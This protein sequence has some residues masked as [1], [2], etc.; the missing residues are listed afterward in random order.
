MSNQIE[1][2]P[3]DQIR[4]DPDQPRKVFVN[5]D[6][7]AASIQ[8]KGL[9]EPIIVRPGPDGYIIVAG[10][11]RYRAARLVGMTEIDAIVRDITETESF[12][13]SLVENIQRESLTPIEE[14]EAFARLQETG[15]SQKE[16][17]DVTGKS[18]SYISQK[19]RLLKLP[20]FIQIFMDEGDLTENHCRQLLRLRKAYPPDLK[21]RGCNLEVLQSMLAG[22]VFNDLEKTSI[23][24]YM[25]RPME[26]APF[27]KVGE[28][29][30]KALRMHG[31]YVLQ[32]K[33][34]VPQWLQSALYFAVFVTEFDLTVG[35]LT[36]FVDTYIDSY[37]GC[38]IL[39]HLFT[40]TEKQEPALFW[41]AWGDLKHAN[42][43]SLSLEIDDS[44]V[45]SWWGR[46]LEKAFAEGSHGL[47]FDFEDMK[48]VRR[49]AVRE[50][51]KQYQ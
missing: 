41:A 27:C 4:P 45:G 9:M 42:S 30:Q 17:M 6:E 21:I 47:P 46:L 48:T 35:V 49:A 34:D 50:T 43:L 16:I 11:R 18:Q 29:S 32:H 44:P 25:Q 10:E 26:K 31:N 22:E 36:R 38:L 28:L 24:F 15:L 39:K 7:L 2:L 40:E 13:L 3:L 8:T 1:R 14:A 37:H 19:L 23:Y 12:Q 33:N 20:D 5:I 51:L